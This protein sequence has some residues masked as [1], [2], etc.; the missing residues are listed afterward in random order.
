ML[1]SATIKAEAR[2]LGFSLVG[3]CDPSPPQGLEFTRDWLRQGFAGEMAYM[4]ASL[5][6][7]R[8]LDILLPGVRSVV[9]CGLE[10]GP[11]RP[12]LG[13][14]IRIAR[15]ALGRDYHKVL[16]S[17]L[18]KIGQFLDGTLP[19]E[20]HRP[21][22]DSAPV[23]EREYANRAGLGWFGKN[24]MLINS[25]RG[26]WFLLGVLL[27]TAEIARDNVAVGG[28]GTCTKCIDSCPTGAIVPLNGRWAV[29]SRKCISYLT[30]EKRGEIAPELQGQ[31][32]ELA[33]GCDICQ[34]VC[35][36]NQPRPDQPLR[37]QPGQDSD[38]KDWR[39]WPSPE[40]VVQWSYDEWDEATR[41]SAVRR[42]GY[43]GL[44][45]NAGIVARNRKL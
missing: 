5:A 13:D 7:R 43:E 2:R 32:G 22:V 41:G 28:C 44:R 18:K 16:R 40:T 21:C 35:P 1:D 10:Y 6:L 14:G 38:L 20:S 9:A 19:G 3:V 11:E 37:A 29:D 27:T 8:D 25:H 24:T 45:R 30:I 23:F 4:E 33:F 31:I 26:S 34:E 12:V 42:A 36:F 17:K 15:Y 39:N